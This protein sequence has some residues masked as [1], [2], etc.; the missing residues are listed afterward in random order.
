[1]QKKGLQGSG[2]PFLGAACQDGVAPWVW[3]LSKV[4]KPSLVSRTGMWIMSL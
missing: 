3:G 2:S 4:L 1:M